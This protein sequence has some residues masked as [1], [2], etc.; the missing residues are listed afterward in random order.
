[1]QIK[2]QISEM[3]MGKTLKIVS[4]FIFS[5]SIVLGGVHDADAKKKKKK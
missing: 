1:M 5:V 4:L 3:T 2:K